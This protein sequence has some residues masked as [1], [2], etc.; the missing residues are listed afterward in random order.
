MITRQVSPS[1]SYSASTSLLR[2]VKSEDTDAWERLVRIYAP[3]VYRW[4]RRFGLQPAD[5]EDGVGEVFA[6]LVVDIDRFDKDGRPQSFRRWLS[7]VTY[8]ATLRIRSKQKRFPDPLDSGEAVDIEKIALPVEHEQQLM[9]RDELDWVQCQV[10]HV[11][12]EEFKPSHW[13]AFSQTVIDGLDPTTVAK[14]L[15]VSVWSVYKA[16]ATVLTRLRQELEG[17]D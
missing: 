1:R 2:R 10:M 9:A 12:K 5:A 15:G 3:Y 16:R 7:T 11:I 13:Q 6:A 8:H 14:T 17:H 4:A